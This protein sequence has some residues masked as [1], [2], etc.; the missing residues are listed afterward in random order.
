MV[1]DHLFDDKWVVFHFQF[2]HLGGNVVRCVFGVEIHRELGDVFASVKFGIDEVDGDA[3]HRFAS[4]LHRFVYVVSPHALAAKLG[5]EGWMNVDDAVGEVVD[6][7]CWN[8][9]EKTCEDD[10]VAAAH[11][12]NHAPWFVE[13][14]L[15]GDDGGGHSEFLGAHKGVGVAAAAHDDGYLH[16]GLSLEVADDIF[17]VCTTS[18]DEDGEPDRFL[19]DVMYLFFFWELK[20]LEGV[21]AD[22]LS[23][24]LFL[25]FGV[26][27]YPI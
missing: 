15:T 23:T 6:E 24:T 22:T 19:H 13:Q 4:R 5:Q 11:G 16:F 2:V 3:R 21:K 12:L 1:L 25:A 14:L 7:V 10:V 20:E 8:L 9:G 17:T 26:V 27:R 18:C